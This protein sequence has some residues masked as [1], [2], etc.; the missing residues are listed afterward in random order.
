[1]FVASVTQM[2]WFGGDIGFILIISMLVVQAIIKLCP[3]LLLLMF[4][5]TDCI[6]AS[7]LSP[8]FRPNCGKNISEAGNYIKTD[9]DK[10]DDIKPPTIIFINFTHT[11]HSEL[12][13]L[14]R[15][16]V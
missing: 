1:M 7:S 16:T 5:I 3:Q 14:A 2:L 6:M 13:E 10:G 11:E 9:D 12:P 15:L 8:L 4:L